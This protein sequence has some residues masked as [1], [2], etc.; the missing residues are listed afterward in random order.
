MLGGLPALLGGAAGLAAYGSL[1]S[2][3]P[4]DEAGN[5]TPAWSL[6]VHLAVPIVALTAAPP[7][8]VL[9][10]GTITH[11][12]WLSWAA[13]PTGLATG[14][15]GAGYFGNAAIH[16]LQRQQLIVLAR[17]AAHGGAMNAGS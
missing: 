8:L 3:Q 11:H 9:L 5:P 16:R 15:A 6:K 4:A 12:D 7:A 17:L 14:I 1:V 2:V 10:A 13:I